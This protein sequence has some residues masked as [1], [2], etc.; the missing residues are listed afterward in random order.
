MTPL[1]EI[2]NL[3]VDFID[4]KSIINAVNSVSL[5]IEKGQ[6]LALVGES[7]SGK[8][9]TAL[10]IIQLLPYPKAKHSVSSSIKLRG[11]EIIGM[12]E[13]Q[14]RSIRGK[15][16]SMIFQEPMTSLN[17]FQRVGKQ[18]TEALRIHNNLS[19]ND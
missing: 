5:S 4:K 18:I 15:K 19:F 9:V 10:S 7:G 8:S 13:S 12:K 11:E 2:K 1:L 6:T 16:I 14:I 17:P 3:R